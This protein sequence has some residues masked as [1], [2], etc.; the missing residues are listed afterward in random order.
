M[1]GQGDSG[2]FSVTNTTEHNW[3]LFFSTV[4]DVPRRK[5]MRHGMTG[6]QQPAPKS[7]VSWEECR[8]F[9]LRFVISFRH[10]KA[11]Y[12]CLLPSWIQ[13][14]IEFGVQLKVLLF[15]LSWSELLKLHCI[16]TFVDRIFRRS[17]LWFGYS[18]DGRPA[19]SGYRYRSLYYSQVAEL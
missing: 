3:R 18:T 1:N 10:L 17:W 14:L 9:L 16:S 12:D 5:Y 6:E 7:A 15:I 2:A 19:W 13:S 8:R 4:A 11:V